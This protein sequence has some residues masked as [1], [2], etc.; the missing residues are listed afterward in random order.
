MARVLVGLLLVSC[1]ATPARPESAATVVEVPEAAGSASP[2]EVLPPRGEPAPPPPPDPLSDYV[3]SWDGMV[4]E[5]VST[6]LVIENN[7]RFRVS[8]PATSF[9]S[10]CDLSGRF[11]ASDSVVWMDV[12]K[13]SCSVVAVG[14]TLERAVL[15][16]SDQQFTVKSDDGTLVIRYTRR[17]R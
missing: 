1:G 4:N 2:R 17:G 14:S 3:G 5:T 15:S 10:E 7:G 8:A 9:R 12:E 6:E 16:K 13:S 11:R